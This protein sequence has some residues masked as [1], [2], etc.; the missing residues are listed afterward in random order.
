MSRSVGLS[1]LYNTL[2]AIRVIGLW[3]SSVAA[4]GCIGTNPVIPSLSAVVVYENLQMA[5]GAFL[6][7]PSFLNVFKDFL[8][9][10][11]PFFLV[12]FL[13]NF[14]CD[15]NSVDVQPG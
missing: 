2:Y 4:I 11:S 15:I 6:A 7:S 1:F 8:A 9:F 10:S 3:Q 12:A 5:N 14:S 13:D